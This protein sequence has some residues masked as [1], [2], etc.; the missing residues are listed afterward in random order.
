[1]KNAL[2][3]EW[4]LIVLTA[5]SFVGNVQH[6]PTFGG[7]G[8]LDFQFDQP[9]TGVK[10]VGDITSLC[11]NQVQRNSVDYF[12]DELRRRLGL[13]GIQGRMTISVACKLSDEGTMLPRLPNPHEFRRYVFN[14][15]FVAFTSSIIANVAGTH[16]LDVNNEKAALTIQFSPGIGTTAILPATSSTTR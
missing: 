15:E 4:E 16:K 5:L 2:S 10:I 7:N 11:D 8:K 1:V 14:K 13:R 12:S 9:A 3:A 6:E